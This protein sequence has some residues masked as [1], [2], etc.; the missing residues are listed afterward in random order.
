MWAEGTEAVGTFEIV[1][2]FRF[3]AAHRIGGLPKGHPCGRVHGHSYQVEVRLAAERLTAPGFV[4]DFGEL[5]PLGKYLQA[6]FDH[7]LLNDVLDVEPTSENFAVHLACWFLDNL[8]P[9]L[10]GRLVAVRVAETATSWAEYRVE[11]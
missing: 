7:Q 10:P 9:G 11:P 3:E 2:R 5:A 6:T 4:T 1:K 8:Q